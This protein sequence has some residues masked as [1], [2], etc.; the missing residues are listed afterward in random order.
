MSFDQLVLFLITDAES[1]VYVVK[2][3]K[4]KKIQ[5]LADSTVADFIDFHVSTSI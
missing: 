2:Q 3:N 5:K 1:F 4:Q